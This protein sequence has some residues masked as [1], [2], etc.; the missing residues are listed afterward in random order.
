[1]FGLPETLQPR[2]SV[3]VHFI[4]KSSD[5]SLPDKDEKESE[6]TTTTKR[7]ACCGHWSKEFFT[8][9]A[10]TSVVIGL[11]VTIIILLI[12]FP[13]LSPSRDTHYILLAFGF[14][15]TLVV[16]SA[17]IYGIYRLVNRIRKG[18]DHSKLL[19][20]SR[21]SW[22]RFSRRFRHSIGPRSTH[23]HHQQRNQHHHGH[24][25]HE[26]SNYS[27]SSCTSSRSQL[28]NEPR[29]YSLVTTVMRQQQ[30]Q[31]SPAA[32]PSPVFQAAQSDPNLS[33]FALS[34]SQLESHPHCAQHFYP[35]PVT[36][37]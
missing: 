4:H 3:T 31:A 35:R 21:R 34:V 7:H 29:L 37:L 8:C 1:M 28:D 25:Q 17:L 32:S 22:H 12:N 20:S 6:T 27:D 15:F 2:P 24:C 23:G 10:L 30:H 11:P 9:F 18:P 19:R 5:A 14:P 26:P 36:P 16:I 33:Q 13:R